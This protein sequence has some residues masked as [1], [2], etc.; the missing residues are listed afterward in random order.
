MSHLR[1]AIKRVLDS[2]EALCLNNE[3]DKTT[4]M[5]ALEATIYPLTSGKATLERAVVQTAKALEQTAYRAIGHWAR[6]VHVLAIEKGWWENQKLRNDTGALDLEAVR[7]AMPE[8]LILIVREVT[9]ALEAGRVNEW[10][11]YWNV[12]SY[13]GNGGLTLTYRV[14][15]PELREMIDK[16]AAGDTEASAMLSTLTKAIGMGPNAF[17]GTHVENRGAFLDDM[18]KIM[19]QKHKPEG[20]GIELVDS[21][22]RTLDL[23]EALG[24]DTEAL[25]QMKHIYNKTRSYR[26]GNKRF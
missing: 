16:T 5:A 23:L 13:G 15:L 12:I 14:T 1:E 19:S 17:E 25:M 3:E 7:T 9:E 22:I 10:D 26:H 8:K 21:I 6:K 24:Y 2:N 4:L 20:V 18:I 11:T